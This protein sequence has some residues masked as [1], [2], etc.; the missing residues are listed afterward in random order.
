ME[1]TVIDMKHKQSKP[2]DDDKIIQKMFKKN[3][4]DQTS[5]KT[6]SNGNIVY[7]SYGIACFR[8]H[9]NEFSILLVKRRF[10][11]S[12]Y[13]FVYGLYRL[14]NFNSLIKLFN[15]MTNDEKSEIVR[16]NFDIL[17]NRLWGLSKPVKEKYKKI[18]ETNFS[19][20]V[21]K[22]KLL[23]IIQSSKSIDPIWEIPK[24]HKE[25]YENE[26]QCAVREFREETG[27]SKTCYKILDGEKT[28]TDKDNN[29][30][31]VMK[32]FFALINDNYKNMLLKSNIDHSVIECKWFSMSELYSTD[33]KLHKFCKPIQK[34]IKNYLSK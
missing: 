24:G 10:T 4:S 30:V 6:K 13:A 19:N 1:M 17:W 3:N 20:D 34:F 33:K 25:P 21:N 29:K 12:F 5:S 11:Y 18:F 27:L 7:K 31:Y 26:V 9:N 2:V 14:K 28:E 22:Q 23:K 15:N 8:K 16:W 32:Y